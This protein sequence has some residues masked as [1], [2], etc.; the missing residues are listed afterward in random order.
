MTR[1]GQHTGW[2]PGR[3][4]RSS[5]QAA[6]A[7]ANERQNPIRTRAERTQNPR[8]YA[9]TDDPTTCPAPRDPRAVWAD[10]LDLVA[11]DD[12]E[13]AESSEGVKQWSRQLDAQIKSRLAELRRRLTSTYVEIKRGV[14]IPP[15][16][17]EM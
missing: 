4:R 9:M 13:T 16:I 7:L 6:T 2:R 15:E 12:A 1:Y 5:L 8:R 11:E 3:V 10:I 14:T 17:R